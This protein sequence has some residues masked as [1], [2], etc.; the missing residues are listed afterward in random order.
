MKPST[1]EL[2]VYKDA[3]SKWAQERLTDPNTVILDLESTGLLREDP[4][5]EIAQI[6]I[7]DIQGRQLLSMLVKPNKPMGDRVIAIHHISND[8]VFKQPTFY[9]IAKMVAFVLKDKHVVAWN[10]EFDWTLLV[11]MFKKYKFEKPTVAGLSCAMDKYSEWAGEWSPKKDGFKWQKLPNFIG[12]ASHDAYVDC[13]NAL[14]AMR[15]MAGEFKDEE[16]TAS[17]I[18]L[19]F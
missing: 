1:E 19:D 4:E 2:T 13:R 7:T 3:A 17:D 10:L 14:T 11:H 12:D 5:T 18:S 15:K 9:Q 16:L 8:Q 6:C